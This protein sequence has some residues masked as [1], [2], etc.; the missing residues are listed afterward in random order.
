MGTDSAT[1]YRAFDDDTQPRGSLQLNEAP[2][3]VKVGKRVPVGS[4]TFVRQ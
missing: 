2:Y 3:F 1:R 4:V